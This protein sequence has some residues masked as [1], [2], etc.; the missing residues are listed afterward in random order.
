[1]T[2]SPSKASLHTLPDATAAPAPPPEPFEYYDAGNH[3]CKNCNATCGSMFDF[4]THL[5]SK[6]HLKVGFH[7]KASSPTLSEILPLWYS[8]DIHTSAGSS[9]LLCYISCSSPSLRLWTRMTDP[10]L[11]LRAKSKRTSCQ[12]RSWLNPLKVLVLHLQRILQTYHSLFFEPLNFVSHILVPGGAQC[13]SLLPFL[14][15][16]ENSDNEV[17]RIEA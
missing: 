5:H 14:S 4:F 1:M 3:W 7:F 17:I 16:N 2:L 12:T 11:P 13:G 15:L 10:G 6:T 9:C 8:V